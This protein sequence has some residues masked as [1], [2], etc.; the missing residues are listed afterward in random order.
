MKK[1]KWYFWIHHSIP[2][3]PPIEPK[4]NLK[5]VKGKVPEEVVKVGSIYAKAREAYIKAVNA[6][7][8][9]RDIYIKAGD[10]YVKTGNA[11]DKAEDAYIKALNDNRK[12]IEALI[13]KELPDCK[14]GWDTNLVFEEKK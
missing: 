1:L 13:A 4:K 8:K 7:D 9:A 12:E 3:E 10:A 11:R 2:I 14:Y 6:Y 5:R